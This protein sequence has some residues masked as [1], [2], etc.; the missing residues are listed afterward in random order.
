M[1]RKLSDTLKAPIVDDEVAWCEGM[2][3]TDRPPRS[4]DIRT[5]DMRAAAV[6]SMPFLQR[7]LGAQFIVADE[8]DHERGYDAPPLQN[9]AQLP[10]S[11]ID[12][13]IIESDR[14][15]TFYRYERDHNGDMVRVAPAYVERIV[16]ENS[17]DIQIYYNDPTYHSTRQR[18]YRIGATVIH[19][20]RP[21]RITDI[22]RY[23]HPGD[24]GVE[25]ERFVAIDE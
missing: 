13:T 9:W 23:R 6:A 12:F 15:L 11:G 1:K 19:N 16:G 21:F 25:V 20:D 8:V 17:L 22:V 3:M 10:I 5:P 4:R 24:V 18:L 14:V 7:T 2:P